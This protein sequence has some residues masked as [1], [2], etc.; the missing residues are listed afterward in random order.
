MRSPFKAQDQ[1]SHKSATEIL[2]IRARIE[3]WID[4]LVEAGCPPWDEDGKNR[5]E[6]KVGWFLD[7]EEMPWDSLVDGEDLGDCPW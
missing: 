2:L 4:G 7:V 3:T 6:V 5:E 1:K